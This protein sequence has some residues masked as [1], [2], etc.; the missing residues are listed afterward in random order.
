MLL[1][2]DNYDSFTYN[3]V[4]YLGEMGAE[5]AIFRNDQITLSEIEVMQPEKIVIS[6]GPCTPKEAGI[7]IDVIRK[8]GSHIPILGVCLGHQAIGEAFGGEVI[9]APRLM[10][11]KTSMIKHDGHAIYQRLPNPF[12]ATRY[13]SLIIRRESMPDDLQITAWTQEGE[14]MGV[15][16]KFFPVEGV[17]FHPES[18]LTQVGKDLLKN[19]L[20]MSSVNR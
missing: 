4:Q 5:M 18:I 12:E 15:R 1:V 10:H 14:I 3:L 11:G 7:S 8:F 2:I 19:F 20:T 6:P 16:H 9:R 13:H 17:Q